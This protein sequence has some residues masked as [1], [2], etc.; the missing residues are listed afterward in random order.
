MAN[1]PV[2]RTFETAP[3]YAQ[4]DTEF[5]FFPGFS[6]AQK[7]RCIVSLHDSFRR[8]FPGEKILEISSKSAE[9]LGVS[10]SAFNLTLD[11]ASYGPKS[12][13]TLYQ[14]SK[15]FRDDKDNLE[16]LDMTPAEAKQ[17]IRSIANTPLKCFRLEGQEFP[18]RPNILFYNWLYLRALSQHP[19]LGEPLMEYTAF[20]DIVFNP[21][22]SL[23]CQARAAAV[24][25][26]LVKNGLL[27]AALESPESFLKIAFHR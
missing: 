19:E 3:F 20:T 24:Y 11:T 2:F 5:E 8:R 10:L 1:R 9:P 16:I 26:G 12:V 14:A 7:Q 15:V 25:V 22:R 17:Y 18:L 21:N 23:N 6:L 27:E 4:Y 13:E